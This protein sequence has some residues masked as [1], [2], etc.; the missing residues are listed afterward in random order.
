MTVEAMPCVADYTVTRASA[1]VSWP[2]PFAVLAPEHV[3]ASLPE[4]GRTLVRGEEY[5]V[6]GKEVVTLVPLP[7]GATLRLARATPLEQP[8][9]WVEGQALAAADIMAACDRL[10]LMVQELAARITSLEAR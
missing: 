8:V 10:T 4:L 5:R 1:N 6:S 7:L 2:L 9:L 3:T